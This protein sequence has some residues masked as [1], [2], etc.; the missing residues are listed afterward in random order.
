MPRFYFYMDLFVQKDN[1]TVYNRRK[2]SYN[3][4][5]DER[6]SSIFEFYFLTNENIR[7]QK[8]GKT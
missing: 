4:V 2:F 5:K 7:R 8:Y 6:F 1:Y 3:T